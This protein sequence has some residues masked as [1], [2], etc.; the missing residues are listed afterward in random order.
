MSMYKELGNVEGS[1]LPMTL[2]PVLAQVRVCPCAFPVSL[3]ATAAPHPLDT[4]LCL[5]T[6][7]RLPRT[8]LRHAHSTADQA[9]SALCRP[10]YDTSYSASLPCQRHHLLTWAA[11]RYTRSTRHVA[12][13]H[14]P[15][16]LAWRRRRRTQ[17]DLQLLEE[18]ECIHCPSF[19][20]AVC[21]R[22]SPARS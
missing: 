16:H 13:A 2:V 10:R 3:K 21:S 14:L 5:T 12:I 20:G 4:L 17:W 19:T 18:S 7:S 6:N 15:Y 1:R 22:P 8:T 11:Y 9:A